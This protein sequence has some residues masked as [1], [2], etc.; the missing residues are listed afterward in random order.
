VHAV[1]GAQAQVE[2][3]QVEYL[4]AER[5]HQL[6]AVAGFGDAEIV[7]PQIL[8]DELPD[9]SVVVHDQHVR[10]ERSAHRRP[11]WA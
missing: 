6:A 4:R 8:I 1:I 11:P 10:S 2:Q 3:H 7:R 9:G 5:G